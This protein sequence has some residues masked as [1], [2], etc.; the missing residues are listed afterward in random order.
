M[1]VLLRINGAQSVVFVGLIFALALGHMRMVSL[2]SSL[3]P[4]EFTTLSLMRYSISFPLVSAVR[5]KLGFSS[6]LE[7]V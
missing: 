3:Q 6:G 5:I 2:T 4:Y 1:L 7:L